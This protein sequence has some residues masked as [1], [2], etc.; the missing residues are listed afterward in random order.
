[1]GQ[2]DR[3]LTEAVELGVELDETFAPLGLS[4]IDTATSGRRRHLRS[5]TTLVQ[6]SFRTTAHRACVLRRLQACALLGA[7]SRQE[8]RSGYVEHHAPACRVVVEVRV[9]PS[10]GALV[11]EAR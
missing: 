7:I 4:Q 8:T 2:H 9:G 10:R 1:M 3:A 11:R 5:V 6:R